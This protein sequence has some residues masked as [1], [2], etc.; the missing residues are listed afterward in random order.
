MK[1]ER[2]TERRRRSRAFRL[3]MVEQRLMGLGLVLI[4]V[5][6]IVICSHGVTVE[7]QDATAVLLTLPLGL[8]LIF[9]KNICIYSKQAERNVCSSSRRTKH[10]ELYQNRDY[11]DNWRFEKR[12]RTAARADEHNEIKYTR[13]A[14]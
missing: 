5:L 10:E 13:R 9:T 6:M 14:V 1:N 12:S 7:D 8:Y 2:M 4:S 11:M 3:A